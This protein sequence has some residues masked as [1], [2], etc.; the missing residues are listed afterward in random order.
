VSLI[1]E[2]GSLPNGANSYVSVSD[3]RLFAAA[4]GIAL[5]S[6]DAAVEVLLI[7]AM[8]YVESFRSEFQGAKLS[9]AQVLQWPRTGVVVDGFAV[10]STEIPAVLPKAQAQLACDVFALGTLTPVGSGRVVIEQRVEGAVDT[11][12]ADHGDSNPQPQLTAARALLAPLM[13]G[14]GVTGF[15]VTVRV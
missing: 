2:N 13:Q 8:D 4:R 9:A 14:G 12:Y 7:K 3:T 10:A 1:V 11:K 6:A 15:G 5:P